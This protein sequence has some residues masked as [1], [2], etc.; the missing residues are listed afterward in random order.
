MSN[1]M[2]NGDGQVFQ[3]N[4]MASFIQITALVVLVSYCLVIVGPFAGLVVWGVVVAVAIYPVHLKL[5]SL[6]YG[7]SVVLFYALLGYI[8]YKKKIFIKV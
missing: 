8:M 3:K 5:S 4:M 1:L 7:L 6:L 2:E